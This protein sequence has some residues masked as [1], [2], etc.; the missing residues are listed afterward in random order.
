VGACAVLAAPL[1]ARRIG[2]RRG[3]WISVAMLGLVI[4]IDGAPFW[5]SDVGGILSMVP[6]FAVT[7]VLILGWRVRW[8]TVVWSIVGLA[9]VLAGF[10]ALDM[11]RAPERRTHL[12]R[13]VERIQDRGIGDFVVVVQRKLG[14]NIGSLRNSIW[15]LV[16]PITLV[17]VFWLIKKAPERLRAVSDAVPETRIAG[18]G[19]A[20]VA[21]LGYALND[22]G[23]AVPAVMLV[24]A[25]AAF[26]WLLVRFEPRRDEGSER[27]VG[28]RGDE[29]G[30]EASS[31]PAIA[32]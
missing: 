22:S 5:G 28:E 16:L 10:T 19:L 26:V 9:V 27:S 14:D 23:I 31:S 6:A 24:I 21:T 7:A 18:I 11:S 3:A 13:L 12:G 4:V 2:G 20:I 29:A 25:I 1:L 8:K 30:T 32:S 15:G 17:L